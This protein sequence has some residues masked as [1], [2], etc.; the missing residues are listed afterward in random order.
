MSSTVMSECI[1]RIKAKI[2]GN[3]QND[4]SRQ[5]KEALLSALDDFI[6]EDSVKEESV[7][8]KFASESDDDLTQLE[9][10]TKPL[11]QKAEIIP[12]PINSKET[13]LPNNTKPNANKKSKYSR[14]GFLLTGLSED[15]RFV[16]NKSLGAISELFNGAK[17]GIETDYSPQT[18]THILCACA[19]RGRCPRTMKYLMGIVGKSWIVSINWILDSLAA[20]Q[21]LDEKK[22]VV[23]GDEVI[24]EDSFAC[25]VSRSDPDGLFTGL[26]FYL[27][28]AFKGL[29]PSKADLTALIKLAG[30][31]IVPE[32]KPGVISISN[33]PNGPRPG[34]RSF[35]WLFDCI[36]RYQLDK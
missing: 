30:G 31:T 10:I 23:V 4:R 36:S 15:Q 20:A 35:T 34:E 17:V 26:D 14:I 25:E 1:L 21:V 13:Y 8:S 19:P 27:A 33:N 32:A 7:I 22:F 11:V 24:K 18:V 16:I 9:P 28:G 6:D 3:E 12:E 2:T 5:Q 29:G